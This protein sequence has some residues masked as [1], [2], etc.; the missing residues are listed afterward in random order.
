MLIAASISFSSASLAQE[1]EPEI[2]VE[3]YHHLLSANLNYV[4]EYAK[5]LYHLASRKDGEINKELAKAQVQEIRESLEAA[6]KDLDV[7]LK[8]TGGREKKK[9]GNILSP[10]GNT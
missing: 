8:H 1:N 4:A 3:D 5:A 9:G 6:N 2:P 10:S 7:I